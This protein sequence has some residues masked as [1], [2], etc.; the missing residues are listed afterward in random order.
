MSE[1]RTTFTMVLLGLA[2]AVALIAVSGAGSG[3][4]NPRLSRQFAPRPTDPGAPPPQPFELPR[5]ELPQLPA[6]IQQTAL[7]LRDRFSSGAAVP[8]LTPVAASPRAEVRIT[9]VRRRGDQALVRGVVRNLGDR[10]LVIAPGAFSFRDSSGTRYTTETSGGATLAPGDETA[11]D[12]TV[13]LA[14]D[15]G[16]TLILDLPPDPP[17]QQVLLLEIID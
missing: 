16:L 10:D 4:G 12:F 15:F 3:F 8:A 7:E 17:L 14:N 11:F 9:D 1:Q 5:V 13:P 6:E 2:L